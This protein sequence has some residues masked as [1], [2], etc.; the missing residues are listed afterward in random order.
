MPHPSPSLRRVGLLPMLV[1]LRLPRPLA[2]VHV[3]IPS[4]AAHAPC[5]PTRDL[6][7]ISFPLHQVARMASPKNRAEVNSAPRTTPQP[8]PKNPPTSPPKSKNSA[9]SAHPPI[10]RRRQRNK[11]SPRRR[12]LP[13]RTLR[14]TPASPNSHRH[15]D[16]TIANATVTRR[17]RR[18]R[19]KIQSNSPQHHRRQN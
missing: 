18:S 19:R 10:Q 14:Q 9:S 3:V 12:S 7:S 8:S 5:V 2:S 15:H 6:S 17:S 13:R 4:E 1:P 16:S 11:I